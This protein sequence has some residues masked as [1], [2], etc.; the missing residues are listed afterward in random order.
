MRYIIQMHRHSIRVRENTERDSGTCV[1]NVQR[2]LKRNPTTHYPL[3]K[4]TSSTRNPLTWV[5]VLRIRMSVYG[6]AILEQEWTEMSS[7]YRSFYRNLFNQ[8]D[9]L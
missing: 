6:Y 8:V 1:W 9:S 4:G 3:P 2:N 5:L 7:F